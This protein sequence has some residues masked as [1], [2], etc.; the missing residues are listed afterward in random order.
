MNFAHGALALVGSGE[1]S[2]QMHEFEAELVQRAIA[3]G[4]R[5][6]FIQIPTASSHEGDARRDFWREKGAEQA[7]RI[8]ATCI[9]LPIHERSDALNEKFLIDRAEDIAHAGLI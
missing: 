3:R 7:A 8:G 9:Y 6:T 5:N 2:E 4:K 1:Y